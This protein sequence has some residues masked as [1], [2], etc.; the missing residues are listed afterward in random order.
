MAFTIKQGDRRPLFVVVLKDNIGEAGEAAVNLTTA[1][2]AFFNMRAENAG[3][4][5]IN[6]GSA[7]ITSAAAGEVTYSWGTADVNTAGNFEAEM[8]IV[9]N[10]GKEE[11]F[12]NDSYWEVTITDDIA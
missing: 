2:S 4:I 6:R 10:D 11:T 5:K 7:A 8:A 9:W 12:P 1:T 3:A